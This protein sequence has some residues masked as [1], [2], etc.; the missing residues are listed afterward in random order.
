MTNTDVILHISI[1]NKFY[2][3]GFMFFIKT[4][5]CFVHLSFFS[6][7]LFFFCILLCHGELNGPSIPGNK[8]EGPEP[9]SQAT[10]WDL[11]VAELQ[12][13]CPG[14][15]GSAFWGQGAQRQPALPPLQFTSSSAEFSCSLQS[16]Y[17]SSPPSS[18]CPLRLSSFRG[19][20]STILCQPASASSQV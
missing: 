5:I 1:C 2:H 12:G 3:E 17:L 15:V 7:L 8:V 13:P 20:G 11:R 6:F 10:R 16:S 19:P 4:I 18:W 9:W 14:S